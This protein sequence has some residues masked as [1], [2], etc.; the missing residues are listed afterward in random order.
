MDWLFIAAVLS[1]ALLGGVCVLLVVLSVPGTW[2]MLGLALVMELTGAFTM[3]G[4]RDAVFGW[5][6]III[7]FALALVGEA[8]EFG[9]GALGAK[10]GGGTKRGMAG[11]I[12]GGFLGAL[13]VTFLLPIPLVG[14]LIGA[15][16]GTFA[17]AVIAEVSGQSPMTVAGSMRPAIGATL[18][19]VLG[20]VGKVA[21]AFVIWVL[22][23]AAIIWSW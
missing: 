17:G 14:T 19:R 13:L 11:A 9:A 15:L 21:I 12:I 1:F 5:T 22:L 4:E 23:V 16:V 20:T 8:I 3:A 6:A 10:T 2:M 7:S 18:G